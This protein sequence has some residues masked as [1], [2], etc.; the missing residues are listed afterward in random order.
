LAQEGAAPLFLWVHLT[1]PEPPYRLPPALARQKG[2]LV[3]LDQLAKQSR[4]RQPILTPEQRRRVWRGYL[5]HVLLLDH[6]IG[7]LLAALRGSGRWDRSAVIVVSTLGEEFGEQG[8]LGHGGNLSRAVLEVPAILKLP[9]SAPALRLAA[10]PR[11]STMRLRATLAALV[12][13]EA[14]PA[15]EPS[16]FRNVASGALTEAYFEDGSR[17]F[18][19]VAEDLQLIREIPKEG[20]A[21]PAYS[22]P[23][24][25]ERLL[26]WEGRS[27]RPLRAGTL[28][29]ALSERL[30]QA[31]TRNLDQERSVE[32]ESR[33]WASS[34]R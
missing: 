30:H 4:D 29:Q 5:Q 25:R 21:G 9:A 1:E 16:L 20:A 11:P 27:A 6:Q 33:F 10:D 7:D 24:G 17:Q 19:L 14:P 13:V 34:D 31:W 12:G 23:Q 8:G 3:H 26:S 28:Q 18:S 32:E 2:E 22:A 15:V